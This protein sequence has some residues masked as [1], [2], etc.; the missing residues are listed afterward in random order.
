MASAI[1]LISLGE[2][3]CVGT[4]ITHLTKNVEAETHMD[5]F[6][7]ADIIFAQ[8][9]N[10]SYP[11]KHLTTEKLRSEFGDKV[12]SWPNIFFAGQS[13]GLCYV[14]TIN[15]YRVSGPLHDYQYRPIFEAW[16]QGDSIEKCLERIESGVSSALLQA[17]VTTS[18]EELSIREKSVD[19]IVSDLI[20]SEWKERRLFFT[21]N[22]P[23]SILLLKMAERM[24]RVANIKSHLKVTSEIFGEPLGRIVP[25]ISD[26]DASLLRFEFETS[27]VSRG[28]ELTINNNKIGFG[29]SRIYSMHELIEKSYMALDLQKDLISDVRFTPSI[30]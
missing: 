11:V 8:A 23:A 6:A 22:H 21:F 20:E 3:E 10:S 28:V 19:V 25:P 9:V 4:V 24:L 5:I 30:G 7:K 14:T 16:Q 27:S 17:G 26:V 13:P 12:I 1:E 18:F 29:K 15:G 2:G